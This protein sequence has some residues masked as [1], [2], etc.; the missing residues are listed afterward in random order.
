MKKFKKLMKKYIIILLILC[1]SCLGSKKVAE[2]STATNTK[3][4]TSIKND[5]ISS[6]ATNREIKDRIIVNVPEAS[7]EETKKLL[8]AVLKQLNT[9]KSS[10]TNSYVSTY[11]EETRRL[12]IDYIIGQTQDKETNSKKE[13][14]SEKTFEQQTDEY[15]SKKISTIPWWVYVIVFLYFLKPILNIVSAFFPCHSERSEESVSLGQNLSKIY[16]YKYNVHRKLIY[17]NMKD[18]AIYIV[19]GVLILLIIGQ[20]LYFRYQLNQ[21]IKVFE[22]GITT[23]KDSIQ[24]IDNRQVKIIEDA[25]KNTTKASKDKKAINDKQKQDEKDIDNSTI[26]DRDIA[27][28]LSR[29]NN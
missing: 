21:N 8:D 6:V 11:D 7:N 2:K 19:I 29:Y 4:V 20:G 17:F 16:A 14:T 22:K 28:F 1:S 13:E 10:G 26:S 3:E 5:S 25:K 18:K 12:V 23:L 27:D 24:A 15:I 9:S